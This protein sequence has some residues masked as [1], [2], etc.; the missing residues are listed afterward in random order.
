MDSPKQNL[1]FLVRRRSRIAIALDGLLLDVQGC[2]VLSGS[3]Y[4]SRRV[5]L[6]RR[7]L[8]PSTK[9]LRQTSAD[10]PSGSCLLRVRACGVCRT[11]LHIVEGELP[12][13]RS[14]VIPGHQIVGEVVHG[15]PNRWQP[16]RVS[17]FPGSGERTELAG[18]V[19][20]TWRIFAIPQPSPATLWMGDMP[21]TLRQGRI[22]FFRFRHPS[23]ICTRLRSYAPA[24]SAFAVCVSRV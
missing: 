5:N 19:A 6:A 7:Y 24:L 18:T 17:A 15:A 10:R 2:S 14:V 11:D 21:S 12:P 23:T 16:D 1:R 8:H 9:N 20:T 3:L 13:R 22:S 4:E